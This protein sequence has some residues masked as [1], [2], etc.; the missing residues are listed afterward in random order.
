MPIEELD[1][2]KIDEA[3]IKKLD[4][5]ASVNVATIKL[6]VEHVCPEKTEEFSK[7][8][9]LNKLVEDF[10]IE[11]E[12]AIKDK[13]SDIVKMRKMR[14]KLDEEGDEDSEGSP[15]KYGDMD[16]EGDFMGLG[17]RKKRKMCP[18]FMEKGY[19]SKLKQKEKAP[20]DEHLKTEGDEED[21]RSRSRMTRSMTKSLLCPFAHHPLELDMI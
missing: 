19:C 10:Y 15:E 13:Q 2:A 6:F 12:E 14:A 3:F 11:C 1:P 20:K 16:D 21:G 4:L 9:F 17:R 7:H 18:E 8:R 5:G